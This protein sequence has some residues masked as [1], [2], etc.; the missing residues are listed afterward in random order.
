PEHIN[1]NHHPI[2]SKHPQ[3]LPKTQVTPPPAARAT[4]SA[5]QAPT[6]RVTT[7]ALVTTVP[8]LPTPTLTTTP[9]P[10][11]LTTTATRMVRPTTTTVTVVRPTPLAS[12]RYWR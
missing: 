12:R 5:A 2:S 7:T 6:V 8:V 4:R 9:I 1:C 10:T 3:C 11:A